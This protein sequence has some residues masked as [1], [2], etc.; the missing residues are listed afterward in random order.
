MTDSRSFEIWKSGTV[1]VNF[2][3]NAIRAR[4]KALI[5]KF[6]SKV[7]TFQSPGAIAANGMGRVGRISGAA[8][9]QTARSFA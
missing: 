3:L 7:P 9:P 1:E 6:A 8:V 2:L 4:V 5:G